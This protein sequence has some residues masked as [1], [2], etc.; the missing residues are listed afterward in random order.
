MANNNNKSNRKP[1]QN[2][3][4]GGA[5]KPPA[6]SNS[7]TGRKR[8]R[9]PGNLV[10][11]NSRTGM[12][13]PSTTMQN[14][15]TV[16]S[17]TETYGV[18][19]VGS[20]DF[21]VLTTWALQP[22]LTEYSKGSPLG[23]WL[24]QIAGNFDN[25]EIISLGFNYRA[26]CSTLEPG[27]AIFAFEPNPE[28]STPSSYQEMR[29]MPSID[30]SVHANL[31][32]EISPRVRKQ[33][34]TRKGPVVNLPSYDAGKVFFAV[35][36]CTDGAKLGFIDVHYKVRLFNPQSQ[37]STTLPTVIY[38]PL[39]PKWQAV[40]AGSGNTSLNCSTNCGHLA[41]FV[42]G[43]GTISGTQ[44]M[45]EK[46]VSTMPA[47]DYTVNGGCKFTQAS[48]NNW[49]QARVK[50]AGRYR[51]V[52]QFAVD[53]RDL[54]LFAAVPISRKTTDGTYSIAKEEVITSVIGTGTTLIDCIPVCHRGFTGTA[55]GDPNPG[56][57]MALCGSWE[58]ILEAGE[59]FSVACGIRT[60]NSVSSSDATV[61]LRSD[62]GPS[63]IAVEFLGP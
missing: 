18:N 27:L 9:A 26:A 57:D 14:G 5:N 17:H 37:L 22:G 40:M 2:K 12:R 48:A 60:Y 35:N 23:A 4:S 10:S 62:L 56:T 63:Y 38:S 8:N 54:Y 29:N 33:L 42:L 46:Y 1:K 24:P 3:R 51:L 13:T 39:K 47:Y 16:V 43:T 25:Y 20:S 32:F 58:V 36:G 41:S 7:K 28:G 53:F 15:S 44:D 6:A 34:L 45:V 61:I 11:I 19:I 52:A 49:G 55:T 50:Y 31:N 59:S 21:K 30:G